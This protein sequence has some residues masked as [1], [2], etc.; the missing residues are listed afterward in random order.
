MFAG[1]TDDN[2][3]YSLVDIYNASSGKWS[4]A[5]LTEARDTL[6]ATTVGNLIIF[7]GGHTNGHFS[8]TSSAVVDIYDSSSNTWT[9]T[10]FSEA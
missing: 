2:V 6:A 4:T 5:N 10:N 8:R 1:G 3:E 7:A 9:S